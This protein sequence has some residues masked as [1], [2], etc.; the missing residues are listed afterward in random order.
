MKIQA[1]KKAENEAS[2]FLEK[3]ESVYKREEEVGSMITIVGFKETGALRRASLDLT[4][5]LTEMRQ[6]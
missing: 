2:R 1:I 6:S 4:R 5:S 3:I